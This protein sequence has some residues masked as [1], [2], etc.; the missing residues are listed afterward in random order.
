MSAA[1]RHAVR[2]AVAV[3]SA[4]VLVAA[5]RPASPS[6]GSARPAVTLTLADP[7]P[8]IGVTGE[9][10]LRI[11]IT[12]PPESPMPLPRV[13]ASVGQIEDLGRD[14]P[15]A[16]SARYILPSGRF[17][18]PAILVA[19]FVTGRHRIRGFLPVRLRAAATPSLRTDPGAQVTIHVDDRDFG[20]QIARADG[21][22]HVPV[23]V[24][25]GV[26]F[27]TA[28][29]VNE[30]GKATE[31]VIDLR[32]PY[33]QRLLFV[34]PESLAAGTAG[35]VAV[36]AV[37]ASGRPANASLLVM[38][39]SG[40]KVAP[41]GSLLPGEAR[42][43]VS[44]PT[45]LRDKDLRMEAQLKGQST[46][47]IATRV[48]LLPAKA[49]ALRL[50]AEAPRLARDGRTGV[51]VFLNAEDAYGNP[52]DASRA[53]VIVDG[54]PARVEATE[55]AAVVVVSAPP[56]PAKADVVVEGVLDAGHAVRRIPI[57]LRRRPAEK[58]A[59]PPP[60]YTLTPRLGLMWNL[61]ALVGGACFVEAAA[62][63]SSRAPNF[64]IGL[65]VGALASRFDAE[66][67]GGIARTKLTTVPVLFEVH[68]RFLP[69][70]GRAFFALAAGA[71]FATTFGRIESLGA[72]V[73]GHGFGV[74]LEGMLE[75]GV[76]LGDAHL[77]LS[78]RYLAVYLDKLSSGDRLV[79]NAGGAVADIGYRLIW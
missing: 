36:Y 42:F 61:G 6:E 79:G 56:G 13:F 41:L 33:S 34:P 25:P 17:P 51:R 14:S 64:G 53:D 77:V 55:G 3:F 69:S 72:T 78:L 7:L 54:K 45:I 5:T 16:F 22:V 59:G 37:E 32:V 1:A 10:E 46:T 20:P 29:S 4:V 30:H 58:V 71:G 47:R 28:R 76:M 39:A 74:A 75:S 44:A 48:P 62:Y 8:V 19:E 23:V 27:A 40:A 2:T 57:G 31:Q 66:S 60:R 24:P 68:Q 11:E 49:V 52:V 70:G 9:T 18:Q 63:R 67:E 50:E 26:D 73:A 35:E 21:M 38:R 43:L 12:A 65:S 15:T